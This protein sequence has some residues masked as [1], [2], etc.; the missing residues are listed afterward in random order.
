MSKPREAAQQALEALDRADK[1]SGYANNKKARDAIRSALS[2]PESEPEFKATCCECG[3]SSQDGWALYCVACL[4]SAQALQRLTDVQQEIVEEY[5]PDSRTI[6]AYIV[7]EDEEMEP[8]A[9]LKSNEGVISLYTEP[10]KRTWVGLTRDEVLDIEEK[11][12]HP[13]AFY[14][15]IEAKLKEKNT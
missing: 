9:W 10:P 3:K 8:V 2:E 4:E 15:A 12:T 1:I 7:K 11:T 14:D 13:L 6:S 5:D